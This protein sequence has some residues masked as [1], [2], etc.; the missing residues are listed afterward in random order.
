MIALLLLLAAQPAPDA[1]PTSTPPP[2]PARRVCQR[3]P[4]SDT[5]V[6]KPAPQQNPYRLRKVAP[7]AYG[8]AAAGAQSGSGSG[9]KV[10]A[11]ASNRG[12]RNRPMATVGIP[13]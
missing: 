1:T 2:A 3:A 10:R 5:I 4:G 9:V 6:C 13:F 7:Q 12:R 8:P 11:Q